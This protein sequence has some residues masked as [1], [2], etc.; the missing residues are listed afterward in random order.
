MQGFCYISAVSPSS[1]AE[2]AGLKV[3]FER[4]VEAIKVLVISRVAGINLT[5]SKISC[6]GLICCYNLA[7]VKEMLLQSLRR[8][9]TARLHIMTWDEACKTTPRSPQ[10]KLPQ[11]PPLARVT[12]V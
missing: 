10:S 4:A 11:L 12:T 8:M 9:Q 2:Q 7:S 3:L 1:A 5:P 6:R